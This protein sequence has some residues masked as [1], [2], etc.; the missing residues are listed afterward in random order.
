MQKAKK[1]NFRPPVVTLMG[2][3]DHGKTTLLD[4]IRQTSIVSQEHGGITQHIGA[5]QITFQNQPI[6][7]IDTPGH[8][9]FEKMRSRGA[10]VADIVILVVAADDGVKPQTIEAIK[11]IK[12]AQRPT[13]VAITKVDLPNINVE[14]IKSQLQKEGIIVEDL[15]GQVPQ[16]AVAAPKKKGFKELLELIL[17]VW[18]LNPQPALPQDPLEAIVVES[19]LDRKRGPTVT[20]IVKVGTLEKGQKITV[21]N[22]TISVR[23]LINDQGKNVE[24][25]EPG[26]PVEILGFKKPLPSGSVITEQIQTK[27][28]NQILTALSLADI[29]AK[30]QQ[31]KGK[32]K[33]IIKA[34]V[35]GSLEAVQANLPAKVMVISSAVGDVTQADISFAKVASAPVLTFNLKTNQS[36]KNQAARE[37]VIIKNYNVIYELI[38]D[39]ENVVG[40]FEKAKE[41]LQIAGRAKIVAVFN[42]EGQKIA[43]ATVTHGRI[44]AGDMIIFKGAKIPT[45]AK[46]V[47]L[48]KYKKDVESVVAGQE[49]GIGIN[50]Q[51]DFKEG[52]IIESL[53]SK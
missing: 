47:S 4:T 49:C 51:L 11:H 33:V 23:A 30:S 34:D 28:Q 3:V 31:A 19:S 40:Q 21:D 43:G 42:I 24:S 9:A 39:I 38:T 8:A 10:E 13:I 41:E 29:I 17:L 52:D 46:I 2:H 6:T 7:F 25:A 12:A 45:E 50:P 18:Q 36:M 27:G 35:A 37:G 15:G 22:E 1:D 5:Y 48:K 53:G 32:F 16:V 14:K 20:T 44:R 26:Q